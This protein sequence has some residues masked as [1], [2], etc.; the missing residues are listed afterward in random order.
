MQPS[1]MRKGA[2]CQHG[3]QKV[4]AGKLLRVQMSIALAATNEPIVGRSGCELQIYNMSSAAIWLLGR[5]ESAGSPGV[6]EQ[7][8]GGSG[9]FQGVPGGSGITIS[10]IDP[11]NC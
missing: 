5:M 7:I 4:R 10:A 2:Q 11:E 3:L 8:S 6:P 9:G 1:E